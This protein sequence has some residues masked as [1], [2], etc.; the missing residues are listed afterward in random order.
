MRRAHW[1]HLGL[2]ATSLSLGIRTPSHAQPSPTIVLGSGVKL[3]SFTPIDSL[4][5]NPTGTTFNIALV[6]RVLGSPTEYRVSRFSDFRDA[7]W[8]PYNPEPHMTVT[9]NMFTATGGTNSGTSQ[10]TLYLQVRARNPKAGLP[11]SVIG[12]K[13]QVQPDFFFSDPLSRRVRIVFAG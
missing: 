12:G 8:L 1:L 11:I 3:T 2:V 9:S 6:H 13:T 5:L 10:V 7:N 4:F